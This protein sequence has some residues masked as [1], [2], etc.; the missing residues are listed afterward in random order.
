MSERPIRAD[1]GPASTRRRLTSAELAVWRSLIDTTGELE[2]RLGARL[3]EDSGLSPADYR[4]L[5]ALS[6]VPGRRLRSSMLAAAIDWTRSRLSHQLGRLEKRG[7]IGREDC[8]EDNRGTEIVL[9]DAGAASF[10]AAT[11]PHARAIKEL[12]ADALSPDQFAALDD[13]LTSLRHHLSPERD[14]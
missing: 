4:V 14:S 9:T 12:F 6:E 5:L 10:R 13:I 1:A 11:A 7:L 3:T 8:A 2:R